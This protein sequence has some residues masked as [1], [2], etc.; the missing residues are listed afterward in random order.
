MKQLYRLRAFPKTPKGGNKAGVYLFA[1]DLTSQDMQKIAKDIGYS[2]T[3]FVLKSKKADFKVRFFTPKFEVDLCGHATIATFNLLRDLNIIQ[4]GHYTQETKAGIL[5]LNVTGEMVFMQQSKPVFDTRIDQDELMTCF[6]NLECHPHLKPQI[7]STGLREI[8][9]PLKNMAALEKLKP[10]YKKIIQISRKYQVIGIHAFSLDDQIDAY[11]R[12][13]APM[14]GINEESATGTSN[15]A[16]GCYLY[17]HLDQ[18]KEFLFRQGY[19]M[20]QPSEIITHI[21]ADADEIKSIW[22]GGNASLIKEKIV[23]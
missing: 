15:G 9:L 2:E 5:S 11:G 23:V 1:D 13:F 19:Q 17:K 6:K 4:V 10:I 18:K 16:L 20:D 14:I 22:V 7:I 12:N 21:H 8:F 3:A